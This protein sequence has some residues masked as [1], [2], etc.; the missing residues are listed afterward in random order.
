M[1]LTKSLDGASC[2]TP[3]RI[4]LW[5]CGLAWPSQTLRVQVL[6]NHI[7]TPNPKYLIFGYMDPLGN[8]GS[9]KNALACS[10]SFWGCMV[11][12]VSF[13]SKSVDFGGGDG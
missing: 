1:S 12:A 10:R 8:Y 5:V 2:L 7:L 9:P 3:M 4:P 13:A 6:N 11:A